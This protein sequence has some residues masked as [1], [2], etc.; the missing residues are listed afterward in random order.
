[1]AGTGKDAVVLESVVYEGYGPGGTAILVE[2]LTDNRNRAVAEVRRVFDAAGVKWQT[3]ELGKVDVGGGGT[4]AAFMARYGM[5]V[6]DCGV[7]LLAMHAPWEL[8]GKFDVYM[9]YKGY[10]AFMADGG[11]RAR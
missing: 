11:R 9:T 4:I 5:D 8:S 3:A 10:H 1:G 2:V 7:S 6:L